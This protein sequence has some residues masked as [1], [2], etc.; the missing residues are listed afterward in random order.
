MMNIRPCRAEDIPPA[1][2]IIRLVQEHF[3]RQ[4]VDQ[5]QDGYPDLKDLQKD[6]DT[7]CAFAIE[8]DGRL[9]GYF[10]LCFCDDP[11]YQNIYD[12]AWLTAGPYAVLHRLAVTPDMRRRGLAENVLSYAQQNA[13]ARGAVSLRADTHEHNLPTL[14]LLSKT[15]FTRCGTIFVRK[16]GKRA[17]FEKLLS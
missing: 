1:M 7:A 5:W 13:R 11:Y 9:A 4:G 10:A 3:R 17:A 6:L 2:A 8:A 14:A 16:H 15:G 12:G